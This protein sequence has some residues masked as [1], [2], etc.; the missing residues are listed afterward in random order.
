LAGG[1]PRGSQAAG[2]SPS[3]SAL[4]TAPSCPTPFS[5]C[6][7]GCVNRLV[8]A[9][10]HLSSPPRGSVCAADR[11]TQRV[12]AR[13]RRPATRRHT[14]AAGPAREADRP[15]TGQRVCILL[16]R[17]GQAPE[18]L[19]PPLGAL[20]QP[21]P[22]AAWPGTCPRTGDG[23]SIGCTARHISAW[24]TKQREDLKG[25][26]PRLRCGMREAGWLGQSYEH[27]QLPM[28][29]ALVRWPVFARRNRRR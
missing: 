2:C 25:L 11:R 17:H 24:G 20:F 4:T 3:Y 27:P 29:E 15:T 18:R 8:G 1:A 10:I 19:S 26:L 12:L 21:L 22:A 16:P 14:Q 7:P 28:S 6:R 13:P 5:T 23:R 9:R